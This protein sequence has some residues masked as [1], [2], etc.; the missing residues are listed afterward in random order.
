MTF[1]EMG[2]AIFSRL[3]GTVIIGSLLF[4]VIIFLNQLTVEFLC[5]YL[6]NSSFNF[7]SLDILSQG[8]LYFEESVRHDLQDLFHLDYRIFFWI[9]ALKHFMSITINFFAQA[10]LKTNPFLIGQ[11]L[12]RI[13]TE[14]FLAP[15][16]ILA[17]CLIL[18]ILSEIFG[19]Q[20]WIV[21]MILGI[22]RVLFVYFGN[23]FSIKVKKFISEA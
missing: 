18:V 3:A 21:F 10:D 9:Y 22:F 12:Y 14:A 4:L 5:A 11:A 8:G 17:L 2:D 15:I 19:P 20:L 13:G 6:Q 16:L 7:E 1:K 23:K